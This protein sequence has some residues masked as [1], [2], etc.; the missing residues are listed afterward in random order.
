MLIKLKEL[1]IFVGLIAIGMAQY[2][3]DGPA[4][5]LIVDF[6]R[7]HSAYYATIYDNLSSGSKNLAN[8][9]YD[10]FGFNPKER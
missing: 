9:K 4:G 7:D 3:D 10:S 8:F 5:N 6:A 2:F 1:Q